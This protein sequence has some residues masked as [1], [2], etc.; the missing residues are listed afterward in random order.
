MTIETII[1][2]LV[3]I[4]TT[5][6]G[7]ILSYFLARKKYNS[8]VD[9]NLIANMQ[10]S[11]EFYKTLSDDNKKRLEEVISKSNLIEKENKVL[12]KENLELRKKQIELE[13][14]ISEFKI[15]LTQVM[16]KCGVKPIR[17]QE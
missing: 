8:E 13:S 5:A 4:A 17:I 3:G 15:Q 10:D 7:S 11:L 1:T 16:K 9:H 6:A 14:Q 2:G 12:K